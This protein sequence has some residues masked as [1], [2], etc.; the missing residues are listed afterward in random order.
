MISLI[1]PAYNEELLLGRTLRAINDGARALGEPFEVL[2]AD[3]ASTDRTVAI[4]QEHG[5]R[6]VWWK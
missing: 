4:A 1:I 5:A 6:V 3:D 2:V